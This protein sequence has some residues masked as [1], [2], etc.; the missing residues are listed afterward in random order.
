MG[1]NQH[2]RSSASWDDAVN[3]LD[4]SFPLVEG[5]HRTATAYLVYFDHLLVIQ[6]DGTATGLRTPSQFI[7]ADGNEASPHYILLDNHG[8]QVEIETERANS[9]DH[10]DQS[11]YRMQLLTQLQ[12]A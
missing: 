5:S 2:F 7:E 8:L 12:S 3:L 6:P 1:M 11:G 9:S 10:A 4:H